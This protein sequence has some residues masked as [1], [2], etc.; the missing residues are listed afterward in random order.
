MQNALYGICVTLF[1]ALSF[2][3]YKYLQTYKQLELEK[4]KN[5]DLEYTLQE[6]NKRIESMKIETKQYIAKHDELEKNIQNKYDNIL[7]Q[8]KTTHTNITHNV[9]QSF[10]DLNT[11]KDSNKALQHKLNQSL[12]RLNE[13]EN[14]IKTA[15]NLLK[16]RF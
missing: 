9:T 6:N 13:L 5:K 14:I 7:T 1:L 12:I 10:N 2:C 8:S 15:N 4:Y 11:C 3:F 16:A